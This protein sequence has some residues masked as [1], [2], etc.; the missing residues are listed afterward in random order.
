MMALDPIT[1]A[2]D[3]ASTIVNKIWPDKSEEEKQ[4]LAQ[5]F[6]IMQGQLAL[7]QG[8]LDVNK[9]EAANVSVFVAGWRPFIGWVGGMGL[10]YQF[11]LQP[12]LVW[13]SGIWHLAAV[14]PTIDTTTLFQLVLA[15][16]GLGGYRTLE[17]IKGVSG[18]H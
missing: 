9:V 7:Q 3:L 13:G 4:K 2:F 17:K 18:S 6:A 1:G 5:E 12:F 14:P 16:L 10:A 8:Q 15:L 11:I